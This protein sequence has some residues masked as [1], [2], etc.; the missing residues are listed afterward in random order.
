MNEQQKHAPSDAKEFGWKA[1]ATTP[2]AETPGQKSSLKRMMEAGRRV[3]GLGGNKELPLDY[4]ARL[5]HGE[6]LSILESY[7]VKWNLEKTA[8]D[9]LQNFFDAGGGTL[10][11]VDITTTEVDDPDHPDGKKTKI[12]ITGDANYDYRK[13]LHLGGTSKEHDTKTAGGFGEGAKILPLVLLRDFG[14]SDISFGSTG[15]KVDFYLDEVPA[16]SYDQ[17]S[18]GLYARLANKNKQPGNF[19]TMTAP[20]KESA[21]MFQ[22]SRDLF[23]SSANEDFQ[24]PTATVKLEDGREFGFKFLGVGEDGRLK[25]GHFYDA[26]QRR[27]YEDDKTWDSVP[28]VNLWTR[29]KVFSKDRERGAVKWIDVDKKVIEPM[30]ESMETEELTRVLYAMKSGW[31]KGSFYEASNKIMENIVRQLAKREVKLDFPEKFLAQSPYLPWDISQL[32]REQYT[33]CHNFFHEV[34]MKSAQERFVEMQEHFRT[35]PSPEQTQRMEVLQEA[36]ALLQES[37]QKGSTRKDIQNKEM[38]LY[39]QKDEK[40]IISGQYKEKFVWM[41][42][43]TIDKQFTAALATYLHELDHQ[44]GTDQSAAFSYQVTNSME[45]ILSA[46]LADPQRYQKYLKLQSKWNSIVMPKK[47]DVT[48]NAKP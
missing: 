46:L 18:R 21:D 1:P 41:S 31:D 44:Y 20:D 17:P 15:W 14:F 4:E 2:T 22:Q 40:N 11:D 29:H 5:Q 12:T 38:W 8:R 45:S 47:T 37:F 9:T 3:V 48:P 42:N 26:G 32:L 36:V 34:G 7:Q 16:G 30:I 13:L 43:E 33:L 23:Y 39:S 35:E 10:D 19:V 25:R 6:Y 24:N 27:H 28:G